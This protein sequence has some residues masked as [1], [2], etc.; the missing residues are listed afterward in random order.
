MA[1]PRTGKWGV[2]VEQ[3]KNQAGQGFPNHALFGW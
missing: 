3:Q 2:A 1:R